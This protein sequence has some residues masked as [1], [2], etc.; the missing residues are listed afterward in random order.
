M[1][2]EIS[3]QIIHASFA[4]VINK[5]QPNANIY[6]NPNQQGT[7]YPAWFIVHRSP[8]E[9]QR[10]FGKRFNG[11]TYLITY[12][13]D[14][15]YMLKQNIT[16][17]F[18]QY[19]QIAEQLEYHLQYLPIFG[20]DAV[21]H[22]YD[23]SWS[24]E[25]NAL[26]YSV[27]LKLRVYTDE[28][29]VLTP[30]EVIE[31]L[32]I[33][34]K[35]QRESIV[36][37]TNTEHPEFDPV[38]PNSFSV[39]T[40]RSVNLP[41]VGGRF[42]DD[43]Y[44]WTPSSWDIGNFGDLIKVDGNITANLEWEYAQKTATI[45]FLNPDHPEFQVELPDPITDYIGNNVT[46]PTVDATF[47]VGSKDWKTSGW[48]IGDFGDDY[49]LLEDTEAHLLW[50]DE[51]VYFTV[52]FT[53]TEKPE[54]DVELPEQRSVARGNGIILPEVE[55]TFYEGSYEWTP[56]AWN[57]GDFGEEITIEDNTSIDL[58]WSS[59]EVQVFP[60][61]QFIYG[62]MKTT[63]D[64]ELIVDLYAIPID[65]LEG[66]LMESTGVQVSY[67]EFV[68]D[69]GLSFV[70][71][72]NEIM[73]VSGIQQ[74]YGEF[75]EDAGLSFVMSQNELME[76]WEPPTLPTVTINQGFVLY[77]AADTTTYTEI[78]PGASTLLYS[79]GGQFPYPS[80]YTF[81]VYGINSSE[82]NLDKTKF[83]I[84]NNNGLAYL[85]NNS[86]SAVHI[87]AVYP[88]ICESDEAEV[89]AVYDSQDNPFNAFK[90]NL[91]GVDY[92]YVLDLNQE[93]WIDDLSSIGYHLPPTPTYEEITLYLPTYSKWTQYNAT[94]ATT[95][96]SK[97]NGGDTVHPLYTDTSRTILFIPDLTKIYKRGYY[98]SNDEWVE[99]PVQS[100]H[101]LPTTT[102][103]NISDVE[104]AL[105]LLNSGLMW[106]A[107]NYTLTSMSGYSNVTYRAYPDDRT[108]TQETLYLVS[109]DKYYNTG[110]TCYSS[111][112]PNSSYYF[113]LYTDSGCTTPFY[114][115]LDRDYFVV[116]QS[117]GNPI[118]RQSIWDM[119]TSTTSNII[120]AILTFLLYKT[121]YLYFVTNYT[122]TGNFSSATSISIKSAP[123]HY[124]EP[125][126]TLD[127]GLNG[128]SAPAV[129][130]G[131]NDWWYA[132]LR[133]PLD[134]QKAQDFGLTF[135]I[136]SDN[137]AQ[138][139]NAVLNSFNIEILALCDAYENTV[140][141][142]MSNFS[143]GTRNND[144]ITINSVNAYS[145]ATSYWR[146][147]IT[148]KTT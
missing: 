122:S 51:D 76:I 78:Q 126:I 33:F 59:K 143:V 34:L 107:N 111:Q 6:D 14:L 102:T 112:T 137:E 20:S 145:T 22:V 88:A 1:P 48:D 28:N 118:M 109:G 89:V 108:W 66:E 65:S 140:L 85:K 30:M 93:D 32:S 4:T 71:S 92:Y 142:N 69:A 63:E 38:Y 121:G 39:T 119:P 136:G 25:L 43:N 103:S 7:T 23:R 3:T 105:S 115:D 13:I 113:K 17:L 147:R 134:K 56:E 53:N 90:F 40:G 106:I 55:G 132:Y 131:A 120:G 24:L 19:T 15:W 52:N 84:Y 18:D 87:V 62:E 46:L 75:I 133:N 72:Q 9:V 129:T 128:A 86:S 60:Q 144:R 101:D 61:G 44:F 94:S 74:S 146:V 91:D 127:L 95:T 116:N 50:T 124:D 29:F 5:I 36:S 148:K 110:I 41:Y 98:N 10:D 45:T 100:I 8:V 97:T 99:A 83:E 64:P 67:C 35:N 96:I 21:V 125:T 138:L 31:D 77:T 70:M 49:Q 123:K 47:P 104:S 16:R 27:T 79:S 80:G 130:F 117:T 139:S 73:S 11:N 54:F 42:E 57:L 135:Y 81:G 68:P 82:Q 114:Y 58:V 141:T 37:F 12:Q 26:K 2:I